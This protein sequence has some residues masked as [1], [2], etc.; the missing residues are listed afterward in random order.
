[1][2]VGLGGKGVSAW[3]GAG[4]WSVWMKGDGFTLFERGWN[5]SSCWKFPCCT[6]FYN[7]VLQH[8]TQP[9]ESVLQVCY[10][11]YRKIQHLLKI[12]LCLAWHL[13]NVPKLRGTTSGVYLRGTPGYLA[14]AGVLQLWV[15][16]PVPWYFTRWFR[17]ATVAT[18]TLGTRG[19]HH[20]RF[21]GSS[22]R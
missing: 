11:S 9:L 6:P 2:S 10:N 3:G 7:Y 14:K 21:Y 13:Q 18:H 1:M 4:R 22:C 16:L 12:A 8:H 5:V 17:C 19:N 15:V 20:S